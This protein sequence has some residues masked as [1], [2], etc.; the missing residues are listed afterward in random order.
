LS[1]PLAP[2]AI[3]S[4]FEAACLAELDALKPGNVHRY[5]EGHGMS[6]TDF[7]TSAR[8]AAPYLA[9]PDSSVGLRIRHTIEATARAVG[10]NTNLGI[11]LLCAPLASAALASGG[12]DLRK[13]LATVLE[14]LT[15]EDAKETYVA[16]RLAKAG[17]LGTVEKHDLRSEP[18]VTLFEAMREAEARDRIAW[19]YAHGF[20]DIFTTGIPRLKQGRARYGAHEWAVTD[21]YLSLLAKIPDTLIARKFGVKAA[22]QVTEN[23]YKTLKAFVEAETAEAR[24]DALLTFDK[25]L[26]D[27][28]LN[29]GTTADLT[30]AT[31]FANSL[32]AIEAGT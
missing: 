29:P 8:V 15:V 30:V 3:A 32:Q 23:A 7:E 21:L 16:I 4:A 17:G 25:A 26:K 11:V 31:L 18:K 14:T 12:G 5:G 22:A 6:V 9:E 28:D 19:N 24:V 10:Q 27:R 2:A 13:R 20:A 1:G